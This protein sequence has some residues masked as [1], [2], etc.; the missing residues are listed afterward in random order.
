MGARGRP[1][2][3]TEERPVMAV[4]L[5]KPLYKQVH[6]EAI[7]RETTVTKIVQTALEEYLKQAQVDAPAN[8]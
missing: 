8:V 1:R 2:Q 7:D 6:H 3:Y 4:R 5:P